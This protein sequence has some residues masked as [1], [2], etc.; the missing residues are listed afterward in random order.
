MTAVASL[1]KVAKRYGSV[2]AVAEV[3][4]DLRR[5][6]TLAL[7]GHNGAGKTTLVKLILG[8]IAPTEGLVR[9]FDHD[10][11]RSTNAGL[12]GALGFLPENVAFHDAMTGRE[13]LAFYARLK[14][15]SRAEV[16]DLLDRVGLAAAAGRRVATYSK[17][18]RQRLG[19]AQALI[20]EPDL[21]LLDEPTSGLDP[22]SRTEFYGT[23]DRLRSDGATV[24]ISTHAL[25]EIEAHADRIAVMH[26]ARLIALGTVDELRSAAQL[27]VRLRFLVSPCTTGQLL[28]RFGDDVEVIE[29]GDRV[30]EIGCRPEDK[31]ALLR[32]LDG[33][34]QQ[35]EDVSLETPGLAEVYNRLVEREDAK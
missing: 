12:R 6:E 35:V 33:L 17:G 31:V 28:E 11:A 20:G 25:A 2:T 34:W 24:L 30:L 10:P 27:P 14:R 26:R 15:V 16:A 19:L 32:R 29:R 22:A 8:L 5:G 7:V 21:L 1:E 4:L 3:S 13:L 23:M 9:V 18:M